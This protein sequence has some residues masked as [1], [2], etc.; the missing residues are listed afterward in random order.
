MNLGNRRLKM[1]RLRTLFEELGFANVSTF[2][3]SGN[4]FFQ[5]KIKGD[6]KLAEMI[7]AHLEKS[8]G[9]SVDTFVRTRDEIESAIAEAKFPETEGATIHVA[10]ARDVIPKETANALRACRTEVD[11]FDVRGRE[12]YWLC[13]IKTNESKV[14]TTPAMKA[15]KL[16]S[17]TMRNMTSLKKML[18]A[19]PA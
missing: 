18:A 4:V 5:S 16:P 8:L 7:E 19:W 10:F 2:I 12:F 9:Y 11:E 1:D 15:A 14:W 3:A 17:V 13:R 6:Q